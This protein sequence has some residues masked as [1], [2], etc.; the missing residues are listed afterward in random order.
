MAAIA[1]ILGCPTVIIA[2]KRVIIEQIRE[3]LELRD[4]VPEVGMFYCGAT[5]DGQLIVVGSIQSL[6]SPPISM[7]RKRGGRA[8]Y[9]KRLKRAQQ[10]QAIVKKADLLMVDE[11]DLATS[12]G[13]KNLF[14][15]HFNGRRKY[16]FSA[17]PFEKSKPVDNLVLREHLG[18]VISKSDRRALEGIGR[19]I[20]VVFTMFAFGEDGDRQ[21]KTAFDIAEREIM[22]DNKKFHQM[23][24]RIVGKFPSERNLILLDTSAIEDFG[25]HLEDLISDSKFIYGK[26][27]KQQRNE[28]IKRFEDG[29]L[30]CLIGSK[31]IKRGLDLKGGVDNLIICGGGKQHR[32]QL[33]KIGRAVRNNERG[34]ARVF[35][36]FFLNNYY[37]YRHS[38]EQLKA[39]VGAG[40]KTNVV[41]K[42]K[43]VDGAELIKSRFRLMPKQQKK[44]LL[45]KPRKS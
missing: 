33:Q 28:Y 3:R 40:Y 41:F 24:L 43:V 18:S 37:L 6:S 1:K 19:I 27:S 44:N 21:D 8:M 14:R 7:K 36:F 22:I 26:T 25:K 17:T 15:Y 29:K 16:G 12:K 30:S 35:S 45:R 9:N 32:E 20:P 23:L 5:P 31:I 11:A 39:V 10:F 42:G 34:F 2:E 38:R 4:V 13:Y